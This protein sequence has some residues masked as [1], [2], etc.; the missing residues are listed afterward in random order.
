M[1]RIRDELFGELEF[2]NSYWSGE[3]QKYNVLQMLPRTSDS[4]S[5]G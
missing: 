3:I 4:L 5:R 1:E 2:K